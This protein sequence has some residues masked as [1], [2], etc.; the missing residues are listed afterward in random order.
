MHVDGELRCH[1]PL[2]SLH[3]RGLRVGDEVGAAELAALERDDEAW[4]ARD[5][6]LRL[7]AHRARA[8]QELRDRLLRKGFAADIVEACLERLGERGYLD[9]RAFAESFVRERVRLRP[10]GRARLLQELRAHGVARDAAEAAVDAVFA[11]ASMSDA[12]LALAAARDWAR[13]HPAGRHDTGGRQGGGA[14]SGRGGTGDA[15]RDARARRRRRLYAHL[16]RR[17][18]GG[19]A[20]KSAVDAVLED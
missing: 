8:T 13:R 16:R 11:E 3:A 7:L 14:R 5:S 1:A 4:R 10:R 20:V 17:G 15:A 6:A 9:D 2:E 19:D 12:A 18:F